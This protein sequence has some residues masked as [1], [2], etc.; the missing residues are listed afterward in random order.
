MAVVFVGERSV[1]AS[2]QRGPPPPSRTRTWGP[3]W[4]FLA[5]PGDGTLPLG[6]L[7]KYEALSALGRPRLSQAC[8]LQ[9]G[10][11]GCRADSAGSRKDD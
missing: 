8:I 10:G 6:I 7:G 5:F 11:D 2:R 3:T 9:L 1:S 4:P